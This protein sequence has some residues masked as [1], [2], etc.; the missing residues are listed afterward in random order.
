MA[1][2][3]IYNSYAAPEQRILPRPG[4]KSN[5]TPPY[6]ICTPEIRE[7]ELPRARGGTV[8]GDDEAFI[9]VASDG[10]W[11]EMSS[12]E[13][14][15]ICAELFAEQG[16]SQ[17]IA[18][19]FVEETLKKAVE[20][21]RFT[22]DVERF[23]TLEELK[24]RPPGKA[25]FS[26]RLNLHDDIAVVIIRFGSGAPQQV[27]KSSAAKNRAGFAGDDGGGTTGTNAKRARTSK[28]GGGGIDDHLGNLSSEIMKGMSDTERIET[29]EQII[30]MIDT[31]NGM[32]RWQLQILYDA[33]DADGSGKLELVEVQSLVS[34]ALGKNVTELL[35]KTAFA[36]MDEDGSGEVDFNEFCD[37]FG[38]NS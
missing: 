4:T 21:L 37:F 9:I 6:I 31:F 22:D 32:T 30:K 20:R 2:S 7:A 24:K 15:R 28:K 3:A 16:N 18:D 1:A 23:L 34:K 26:H 12:E 36:E 17:K 14:V 19:L 25:C 35:I 29:N 33:L 13:A 8:H 10:V 27:Y 38:I 5:G 11:G